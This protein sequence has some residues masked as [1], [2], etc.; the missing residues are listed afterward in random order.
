[1]QDSLTDM[2]TIH[3][4]TTA[5]D[6]ITAIDEALRARP[7]GSA[8]ALAAKFIAFL[9][10]TDR[11]ALTNA[12]AWNFSG[13]AHH[14]AGDFH[15]GL[16][17][18]GRA[19]ALVDHVDASADEVGCQALLMI[20]VGEA[21][22]DLG[23]GPAAHTELSKALAFIQSNPPTAAT[24]QMLGKIYQLLA[25]A[26][27]DEAERW[28][29]A[30]AAVLHGKGF[31]AMLAETLIRI[32]SLQFG[33]E[34]FHTALVLLQQICSLIEAIDAPRAATLM[35]QLMHL[36]QPLVT[37][38]EPPT[39]YL[40]QALGVLGKSI[41]RD[42]PELTPRISWAVSW[43]NALGHEEQADALRAWADITATTE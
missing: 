34:E 43:L 33:R 23:D 10:D 31:E 38:S 14:L 3:Q 24:P 5:A 6:W 21:W 9:E 16:H 7:D 19:L 22:C 42:D 32:L 29:L 11:D 27:P 4:Y 8:V 2:T 12:R 13:C 41:R 18:Y 37:S 15:S 26:E 25:F 28:L 36:H 35:N 30:S 17:A 1:M 39:V 40:G 20:N